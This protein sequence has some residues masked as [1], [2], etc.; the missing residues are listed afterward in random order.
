MPIAAPGLKVNAFA[1]RPRTSA[2]DRGAAQRRRADRR[3]DAD[4]GH[5][6]ERVPLC[7]AGDDAARRCARRQRQPHHAVARQG[8]RRRRRDARDL[9]GRTEPAVRHGADR[10]HL[11]C[12][13]HRRRGGLSLYRGRG[14]HHRG[15]QKLVT[16]KPAG[17]WTR[18]L[19]PSADG[20]KL[21][22]G[23]GS[24]TNIADDGM[25]VEEGRAAIYELDLASGTQPH[26][27]RRPAQRRR[28]RLGAER[29]ACS[30]PSSTSA[31]A[32]ATRRR[33]TI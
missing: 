5:A 7:D 8:R 3:V 17:H 25:E 4:R 20:K 27:C 24:L 1:S 22:A 29:P 31:T 11:L 33:R 32:S 21:Y 28:P 15:G 26:L 13:Q 9:H 16:F 23:V 12:R 14:S 6:A 19:L 2:L 30:G 18:S 10:R